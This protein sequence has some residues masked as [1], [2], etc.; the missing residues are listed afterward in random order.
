[1]SG[2]AATFGTVSAAPDDVAAISPLRAWLAIGAAA[3]GAFMAVLDTSIANAS[4]PVIQGEIGATAS[5]G[6]WIGTAY[7]VAEIVVLPLTGWI[8]RILGT[9]RFLFIA[10][11]VFTIF[12]VVCG[13]ASDLTTMIVGRLGQGFSG[14]M[15]IPTAFG[16]VA[17]L[18]PRDQQSKAIALVSLPITLAPIFGPLL[19][20]W[21]TEN[22]SWHLVFFINVPFCLVLL[23]L[24]LVAMP[25][26]PG[27]LS[28]VRRADWAGVLGMTAGLGCLT[29][30]LEEGHREQW[31]ESTEIRTLAI[32]ALIGAGLIAV[33]QF[34]R[35]RPVVKLSL[36]ADRKMAATTALM[37]ICGA[38]MFCVLFSIPQFLIAISGL[39]AA[40]AGEVLLFYGLAALFAMAL[41]PLVTR[42]FDLRLLVGLSM[43]IIGM[44]C[45]IT[46]DLSAISPSGTFI[47]MMVLFG[48][49]LAFTIMPLQQLA[50]GSVD[51]D[52]VPDSTSLITISRNLGGALGLATLASFQEQRLELHRWRIHETIGGNDPAALGA[53]DC[54]AALFGGGGE[55]W[56]ASLRLLDAQVVR[57]AFV[58]SFNDIFIALAVICWT[59]APLALLI[60][61]RF[62]EGPAPMGAH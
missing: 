7:L 28:E 37:F 56:Q 43:A 3:L 31:F 35:Q 27:D 4:L 8:E 59:T 46:A 44:A 13:I 32:G 6:T 53:V 15:M 11:L 17:R 21:L 38:A 60:R 30:L 33:G 45:Y 34:G 58:M 52:D 2:A 22:Y 36:L 1:M 55:A 47:T 61:A 62:P 29:V 40:K 18:L 51:L 41:Y 48:A 19:G 5:E 50:I 49:M 14:G 54:G 26:S 16:L 25:P 57:E 20:G 10:A 39:N 12:S 23:V 9:R 42:L 24:I